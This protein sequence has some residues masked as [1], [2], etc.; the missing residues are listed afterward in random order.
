MHIYY[1]WRKTLL[2]LK[3]IVITA[4]LLS[5]HSIY[6][7]WAWADSKSKTTTEIVQPITQEEALMRM[8][9]S[10]NGLYDVLAAYLN[11]QRGNT[12]D[13]YVYLLN[14]SEY[15]PDSSLFQIAINAALTEKSPKKANEALQKWLAAMPHNAQAH[16]NTLR[17]LLLEGKVLETSQ[18]L[19][20]ALKQVAPTQ[21]QEFLYDLP[22]VYD[23]AKQPEVALKVLRPE[24]KSALQNKNTRYVASIALARMYL[25]TKQHKEALQVLTHAKQAVIPEKKL[26]TVANSELPALVAVNVLRAL[27]DNNSPLNREAKL[28]VQECL[29][30]KTASKQIYLI[31]IKTLL[32]HKQLDQAS[33]QLQKFRR[34]FPKSLT[35]HMLSGAIA[36]T[37]KQWESA[38]DAL[39]EY[40]KLRERGITM[41]A[42]S[43]KSPFI[44]NLL[45]TKRTASTD[46][47][48]YA[49]LARADEMIQIKQSNAPSVQ[50]WLNRS[51]ENADE[52]EVWLQHIEWLTKTK[53][54][55]RAIQRMQQITQQNKEVTPAIRALIISHIYELQK[56][57]SKAIEILNAELQKNPDDTKLLYARG[58]AYDSAGKH[59]KAEHDYRRIISIEPKSSHALNALGYGLADRNERLKEA[60]ALIMKAIKL[61]PDNA[62]IQDSVGWVNYRMGNLP[63]ALIWLQKA[64]INSPRADAAAHLGEVLW[65]MGE[66]KLARALWKKYL[67][68]SPSNTLLIETIR[69]LD[70]STKIPK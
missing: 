36:I 51:A 40:V 27:P 50:M 22:A 23:L 34:Q 42:S 14:A 2:R 16:I 61:D 15:Y 45:S 54:Y 6:G 69:R 65:K 55:A 63:E 57:Y 1:F 18:P 21:I 58:L 70:P 47:R 8:Q 32:E 43:Q 39:M 31:Y 49:M 19:K 26:G 30:H 38:K 10:A 60:H 13:A 68:I 4:I 28:I 24:L 35:G 66:K 17:L 62:A 59:S 7:T 29:R 25:A 3:P 53:H 12:N 20:L 5:L 46:I 41:E 9:R 37:R 52:K 48:V 11:L 56:K 44:K 67:Q 33:Q 64:F